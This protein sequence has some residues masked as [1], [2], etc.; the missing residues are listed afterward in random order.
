[1]RGL[2]ELR[3]RQRATESVDK[4]F[5]LLLG[6]QLS[7]A[8]V[9]GL[10]RKDLLRREMVGAQ[11]PIGILAVL[12][13]KGSISGQPIDDSFNLRSSDGTY[14]LLERTHALIVWGRLL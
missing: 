6:N 10:D 9:A 5:P 1:M 7:Q 4:L 13:T 12:H 14:L 8:L 11:R 3:A 2:P